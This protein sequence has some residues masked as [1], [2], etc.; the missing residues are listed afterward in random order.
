MALDSFT[1]GVL[2]LLSKKW[3]V[4]KA[5]VMRRAV[6]HI[7]EAEDMKDQCPKPLE[8]LDWLQNGGGLTLQEA[9]AFREEVRAEREAK[10]YWWE[11]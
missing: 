11:A 9:E 3:G 2:D 5:E 1:L 4:P 7:K 10:R 6:R 8:A